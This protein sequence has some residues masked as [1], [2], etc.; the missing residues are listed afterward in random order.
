VISFAGFPAIG[1]TF[2]PLPWDASKY[3]TDKGGC[4]VNLDSKMTVD[5]TCF[6]TCPE[7]TWTGDEPFCS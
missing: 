3:D 1:E 6:D 4:V 2:H 5:A 7:F